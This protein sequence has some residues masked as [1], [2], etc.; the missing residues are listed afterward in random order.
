[1]TS[2][3]S[4]TLCWYTPRKCYS[5]SSLREESRLAGDDIDVVGVVACI[6]SNHVMSHDLEEQTERQLDNVFLANGE[7]GLLLIKVWDGLEVC[8]VKWIAT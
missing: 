1:M 4:Q 5:I 8:M 7:K 3:N 2:P 6:T